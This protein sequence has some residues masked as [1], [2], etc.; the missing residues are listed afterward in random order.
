[1]RIV[2]EDT[3][4]PPA[5]GDKKGRRGRGRPPN[6]PSTCQVRVVLTLAPRTREADRV[7]CDFL[8]SIPPGRRAKIVAELLR[9]YVVPVLAKA[10]QLT[11][12]VLLVEPT[13]LPNSPPVEEL[14]AGRL[15]DALLRGSTPLPGFVQAVLGAMEEALDDRERVVLE[16]RYGLQGK[17]PYPLE[18]VGR[19]LGVTRERVRQIEAKALR[20]LR[21]PARGVTRFLRLG[22]DLGL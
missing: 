8:S 6:N 5:S 14:W 21:H 12:P 18:E 11:P 22:P 9:T 7:L 13:P 17:H 15:A 3:N 4:L 16:L 19:K 2:T 10:R 20:K 1:M